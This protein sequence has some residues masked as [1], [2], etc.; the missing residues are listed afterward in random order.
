MVK[1]ATF[2]HLDQYHLLGEAQHG[3][4]RGRNTQSAHLSHIPEWLEALDTGCDVEVCYL[5][6]LRAFD[7]VPHYLL[8]TKLH[9]KGI[10]DKAL[11]WIKASLLD[12]T[13]QVLIDGNLSSKVKVL[14]GV[15]QGLFIGPLF[16]LF[17]LM[18]CHI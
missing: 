7:S 6:F 8:E 12:R 9:S 11:I 3:F 1:T 10:N 4:R 14:N 15:S 18:I 16:S 2:S 13:Q 17:V 5:N